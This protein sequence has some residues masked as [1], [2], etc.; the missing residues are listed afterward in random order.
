MRIVERVFSVGVFCFLTYWKTT[1]EAYG[2][3]VTRKSANTRSV[4]S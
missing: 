3:Y 2:V 1:F 4:K